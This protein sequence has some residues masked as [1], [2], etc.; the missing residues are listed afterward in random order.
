MSRDGLQNASTRSI[1][2]EAG[3][4]PSIL[5][6]YFKDRDEMI[7]ELV[8]DIVDRITEKYLAEMGRYENP[9]TRFDKAVEFLFGP[10]LINGEHSG[11]FYDCWA[12]AKRNDRVRESF[13]MLYKRFREAII[14]LLAE[15]NKSAGLSTAEV[16][17][18]ANM[19]I[20]IQDGVSVQWDMDPENVDL[21]KMARLTKRFVEAYLEEKQAE[22]EGNRRD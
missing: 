6:H 17:E 16:K 13:A 19:I 15:T 11:L 2:K 3:V 21:K 18:L 1:A 14:D 7:E 22:G 5:H 8:K 4:Q 10:E 9:K 20:A 12:E